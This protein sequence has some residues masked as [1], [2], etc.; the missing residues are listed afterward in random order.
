MHW[1]SFL[2]PADIQQN[3]LSI[4]RHCTFKKMQ[5]KSLHY[6]QRKLK[7][8]RHYF[9]KKIAMKIYT[10]IL[11]IFVTPICSPLPSMLHIF[12]TKKNV[13]NQHEEQRET[14]EIRTEKRN[15]LLLCFH[16]MDGHKFRYYSKWYLCIFLTFTGTFHCLC[17]FVTYKVFQ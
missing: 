4:E 17:V 5:W 16:Y 9:F 12:I 15:D 3:R 1:N 14:F 2:S 10:L 11:S 13:N 6:Q 7:N 8:E